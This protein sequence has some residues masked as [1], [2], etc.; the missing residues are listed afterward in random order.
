MLIF[1]YLALS[2]VILLKRF[3]LI[4]INEQKFIFYFFLVRIY[5]SVPEVIE[6]TP[7][8]P[9]SSKTIIQKRM[10]PDFFFN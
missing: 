4:E 9:S 6:K 1:I 3:I 2:I 5:T 8:L 7:R 10:F